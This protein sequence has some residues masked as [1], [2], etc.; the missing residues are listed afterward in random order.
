MPLPP[1]APKSDDNNELT[2]YLDEAQDYVWNTGLL[3]AADWQDS[4]YQSI[5]WQP[6]DD[7]LEVTL[8]YW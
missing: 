7:E 3:A 4:S 8:R 5:D 2:A 1:E 6:L